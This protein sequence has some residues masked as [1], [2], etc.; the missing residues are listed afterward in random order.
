M[1]GPAGDYRDC[2]G[3]VLF[4]RRG[5]VFIG[6]RVDLAQPAWQFPQGGIDSGETP[7]QAA[8]RELAE[9]VGIATATILAEHGDWLTYDFPEVTAGQRWLGRYR[10]QRQKW[11][12]MLFEGPES[13][14]DL[15]TA[16]PEFR[17]WRW[18]DLAKVPT[19][20]VPFKRPVYE[21]VARVFAPLAASLAGRSPS[22][23]SDAPG[24]GESPGC[25]RS[26]GSE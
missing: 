15:A 1:G 14:I 23:G 6:E 22:P 24:P 4:N 16:H 18:V 21:T 11:F 5:L 12:A 19:L 25:V 2:V 26:S 20:I 9:E 8:R 3:I 7:E 13:A 17:A 10:G